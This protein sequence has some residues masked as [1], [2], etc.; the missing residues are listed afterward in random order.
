MLMASPDVLI[1]AENLLGECPLWHPEERA[2]YWADVHGKLLQR[3]D[4]ASGAITRYKMPEFLGSFA[5]CAGP[6]QQLILALEQGLMRYDLP[7]QHGEWLFR[8][9]P[10]ARHLRFN[11]GKCDPR[12]R[13]WAGTMA[14]RHPRQAEGKLYSLTADGVASVAFGEIYCPNCLVWSADGRSMFFADTPRQQILRFPF[15]LDSGALGEAALFVDTHSH[16]GQP[17]GGALD[18]DGCLW[19]AEWGGGRLVRYTPSGKID[20]VVALPTS[21]TTSCAFAG[22]DLDVLV[23]TTAKRLL[24]EEALKEQAG[25]AGNVFA[26]DV[27]KTGFPEPQFGS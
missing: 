4:W 17:D 18:A 5:F 10:N 23:I 9:H 15:D 12:G 3:Y 22:D 8:P 1:S 24:S 25:L 14:D 7:S 13:F 20:R 6:A 16:P 2:L 11:E 27:G 26:V 19:N 21:Q